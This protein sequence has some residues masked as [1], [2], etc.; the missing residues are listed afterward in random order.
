MLTCLSLNVVVTCKF[1]KR[2]LAVQ[3]SRYSRTSS[4]Y[5]GVYIIDQ[6]RGITIPKGIVI[7]NR[8]LDQYATRYTWRNKLYCL[9]KV[10]EIEVEF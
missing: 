5:A 2:A 4:R 9:T 7:S 1:Y 6:P 8:I 3:P 10:E